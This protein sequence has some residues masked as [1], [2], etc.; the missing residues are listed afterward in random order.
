MNDEERSTEAFLFQ[1][2]LLSAFHL[3]QLQSQGESSSS[4]G[5]CSDQS[6]AECAGEDP[7][8]NV[9][10][11]NEW[12]FGEISSFLIKFLSSHPLLVLTW[13]QEPKITL[14][15]PDQGF[16]MYEIVPVSMNFQKT[17]SINIS[18]LNSKFPKVNAPPRVLPLHFQRRVQSHLVVHLQGRRN[19]VYL[20]PARALQILFLANGGWPSALN[21]L[22]HRRMNHNGEE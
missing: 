12:R 2:H 8:A 18:R 9:Y 7:P 11:Q 20:C 22:F 16:E 19:N 13:P 15:Q 1:K 17:L 14:E 6:N 5:V 10:P 21:T 4:R 3:R